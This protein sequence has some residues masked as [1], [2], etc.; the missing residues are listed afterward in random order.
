VIVVPLDHST[1]PHRLGLVEQG[2]M[3][4]DDTSLRERLI[5]VKLRR[6]ELAKDASDRRRPS[7]GRAPGHAGYWRGAQRPTKRLLRLRFSLVQ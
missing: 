2:I 6:D 5:G 3:E 1:R 7:F 4:A